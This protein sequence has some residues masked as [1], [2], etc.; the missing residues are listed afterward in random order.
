[1]VPRDEEAEV[2]AQAR[3]ARVDVDRFVEGLG[4]HVSPDAPSRQMLAD[5]LLALR[6]LGWIVAPEAFDRYAEA[7][8]RLA[9]EEVERTPVGASRAETVEYVVVGTV[10]FEVVLAALRRM[11]QEHY[12]AERFGSLPP[13][14]AKSAAQ[15]PEEAVAETP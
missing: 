10:V 5:A 12:S 9:E 15:G 6:R 7:A 13:E 2:S 11:A 4:W 1:L 3:A 14:H 8:G